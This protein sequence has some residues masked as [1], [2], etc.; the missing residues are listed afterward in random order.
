MKKLLASLAG[1]VSGMSVAIAAEPPTVIIDPGGVPPAALKSIN[2]AVEAITRLAVDQDGG[3]VWR[4]RRRAHQATLSA[5]ETQGYFSPVVT[6]E[7][8]KD[9][10]G[11][12]WD[13]TIEPGERTEIRKVDIA[14]SGQIQ[15]SEFSDRR[16]HARRDWQLKPGQPFINSRWSQEK[17]RLLDAV[18]R[19]DFYFARYKGTRAAIMAEEAKADLSLDVNSGPRVRLGELQVD[20]LKRVPRKLV[21]RYVQYDE[22]EPYDQ[23]K[24]DEWQEALNNTTFF[25]G[26]FVTLD[27][28]DDKQK[29]V[30]EDELQ[31]PVNVRVAESFARTFSSAIS[32]DSDYGLRGE[33]LYK[34]NV[35]FNQP[36]RLETGASIDRKRQR[37]FMDFYLPPTRKGYHDSVGLLV[38][39][40]DIEGLRN[41]RAGIGWKRKHERKAAGDSRV[42]YQ[43]SLGA[44]VAYDKTRYKGGGGGYDVPTL[45]STWRWLRRDVNDIY[46]PREGNLIEAN[47]GAGVTLDRGEFFYRTALRGQKWWQVGRD[48]VFTVRGEV[49]KVWSKTER[50]PEDFGYRT[51]G[52][53]TIRGYRYQSIGIPRG[54]AIIGGDAL[55]VLSM[56]YQHFFTPELGMNVFVDAGD[57]APS[58]RD[59]KWHLGYGVGAT[60]RT[61]AGPFGIDLA[62]GQKDKRLRLHFSLGIA[63]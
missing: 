18:S 10:G 37:A 43:T 41:T 3:E 26:A 48:D 19:K 16:K 9:V 58:F 54:S 20:G 46:D 34:Q 44:V 15:R 42:D 5:L 31:L 13:I 1:V 53:R 17:D 45:V 39:N 49:G 35:V 55:T 38:N 2:E 36:V 61:P 8:G 24:L 63:F 32:V 6:L 14:F 29:V 47:L 57:A 21:E 28:D 30:K 33:V 60:Y 22:G 62:Y 40:S 56:E 50:L 59:L 25:W 12:T 51:G 23:D 27:T 7:V 52:S 11:E 4:L